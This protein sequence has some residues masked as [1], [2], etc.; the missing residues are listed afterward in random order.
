MRSRS[1]GANLVCV[2]L[3]YT[4]VPGLVILGQIFAEILSGNDFVYAHPPARPPVNLIT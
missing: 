4:C 2:L 1:P 3:R